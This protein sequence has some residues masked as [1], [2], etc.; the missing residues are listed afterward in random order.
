MSKSK[1]S[2]ASEGYKP[3][4]NTVTI[5]LDTGVSAER[6]AL[7]VQLQA[8]TKA[9]PKADDRLTQASPVTKLQKQIAELEDRERDH[10][11]T[12][13]FTKL[14]PLVYADITAKH[15]PREGSHFDAS[16]G[17]NHHAAC[18]DAAKVNGVEIDGGKTVPLD[19]AD[20]ETILTVASGQDIENIVTVVLDLNVMRSARALGRLKKD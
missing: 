17:Y 9:K 1:I 10:M 7:M 6:D 4:T 15:E 18:I 3:R 13:R 11:H 5:C 12:L 19:D 14:D 8:A 2:A 20:W 16:L